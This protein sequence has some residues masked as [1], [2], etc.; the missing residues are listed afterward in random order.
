[1]GDKTVQNFGIAIAICGALFVFGGQTFAIWTFAIEETIED[2]DSELKFTF[3]ANEFEVEY[4]DDGDSESDDIAYDDDE[5]CDCNDLEDFFGNLKLMFYALIVCGVAIA[6][7]GNSGDLEN[8]PAVAGITAVLSVAILAYTFTA[9]PEAFEDETE[10][11]ES[12]DE[13]PFFF[14]N[15]EDQRDGA[16]IHL[17]AMPYVGFFLPVVSLTLGGLLVKPEWMS[18]MDDLTKSILDEVENTPYKENYG[19][20]KTAEVSGGDE[21][22]YASS[23][24]IVVAICGALFVFGGQ[25]FAIWT[26][27]IDAEMDDE[28][29]SLTYAFSADEIYF[30][31]NQEMERVKNFLQ[32]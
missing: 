7:F 21:A 14:V 13:D 29:T 1:M 4:E 22:N 23:F 3:G 9:L 30:E 28:K 18:W 17:K 25:T 32:Q 8:L 5:E 2:D 26:F 31:F 20:G 24:G 15:M 6:Y 16:D 19:Y 11:F 12:L 27:G 10:L